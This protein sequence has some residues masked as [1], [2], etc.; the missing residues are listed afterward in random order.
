MNYKIA[1]ASGKGGTGKTTVA[2]NLFYTVRDIFKEKIQLID[3]DVEE[4]NV[5]IFTKGTLCQEKSVSIKIPV[6]NKET[7]KYCGTCADYCAY[8]AL[9]FVKTIPHIAV[10]E[11][12]CHGCGACL[13]ACNVNN[14]ITEKEKVLGKISEFQVNDIS[15]LI[16]GR[17]DVGVAIVLPVIKAAKNEADKNGIV[18]YDAPPGTSC[19]V[20]ETIYDSD[21]VVLVTEPTPF[22]VN[23]L[24]IMV[25][26]VKKIGTKMGVVINRAGLGSN[27][28][29]EYL[30]KEKI[31]ILME[32]PYDKQIAE[33][34]S[35]G[36][37]IINKLPWVKDK[38]IELFNKIISCV[39]Q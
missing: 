27:E 12:L 9:L 36:D 21:Y 17:I 13:Y 10:L 15:K 30:A 6:I 2:V 28:V 25:E 24:R 38:H 3:C 23:D 4:P 5:N 33:I 37:I 11:D 16:E 39:E 14:V 7:C 26:T 19:P 32:I 18:I 31:E 35:K 29:Y 1:V 22:G 34:Y 8:N 20:L